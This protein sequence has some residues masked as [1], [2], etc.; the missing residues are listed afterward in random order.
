MARPRDDFQARHGDQVAAHIAQAEGAFIE[1]GPG[2]VDGGR[3]L[4][5]APVNGD[6]GEAFECHAV[7][8]PER[9]GVGRYLEPVSGVVGVAVE[10]RL[11]II[12][13]ETKVGQIK[14]TEPIC[15]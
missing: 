9:G 10:G 11:Q 14:I 2:T 13:D 1:S 8:D 5:G 4:V 3:L 12:E 6:V 7:A 15:A